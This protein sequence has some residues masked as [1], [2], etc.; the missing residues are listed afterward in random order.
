MPNVRFARRQLLNPE[1]RLD[2]VNQGIEPDT[3]GHVPSSTRGGRLTQP[4]KK[5]SKKTKPTVKRALAK[6]RLKAAVT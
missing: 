1:N 4:A 2:R 3:F 6:D 5:E